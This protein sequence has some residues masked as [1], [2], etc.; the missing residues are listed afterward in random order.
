[1]SL[2]LVW[3]L[4]VAVIL[5]RCEAVSLIIVKINLDVLWP[6]KPTQTFSDNPLHGSSICLKALV[7]PAGQYATTQRQRCMSSIL[8]LKVLVMPTKFSQIPI[9]LDTAG[10]TSPWRPQLAT[11]RTQRISCQHPNATHYRHKP[12]DNASTSPHVRTK[13]DPQWGFH[14]S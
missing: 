5:E 9:Q 6:I 14:G 7:L 1:M 11:Y 13:S 3:F 10:K 12:R 4:I 8:E 2:V